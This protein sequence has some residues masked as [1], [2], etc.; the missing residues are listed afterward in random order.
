[1]R[2]ALL[3]VVLAASVGGCE[4]KRFLTIGETLL[5]QATQIEELPENPNAVTI[6]YPADRL[7]TLPDATEIRLAIHRD[8]S[9]GEVEELIERLEAAGKKPILL[10]ANRRKLGAY[11]LR[12]ELQGEA[13]RI[14]T[15][16]E[17]KACVSPPGVAEAKCVQ[18]SDRKHISRAF[19]RELTREATRAYG[20]ADVTVESPPKLGWADVVRAIDGA[21][22]CCKET[23]PRVTLE[24]Y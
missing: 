23:K 10:A 8:V 20:L 12:D 7:E 9:I 3:A 24:F 16:M 14:F 13:I 22:T 5:V 18:R 2:L 4:S 1:M 19:V 21:R 15:N 6:E 17:G 11:K